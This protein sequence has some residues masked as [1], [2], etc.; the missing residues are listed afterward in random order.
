ME[1]SDELIKKAKGFVEDAINDLY[2][3]YRQTK[4][5]KERAD[6]RN[7]YE[8]MVRMDTKRSGFRRFVRL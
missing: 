7:V 1:T 8:E 3:R 2:I 4:G 5:R 6:L